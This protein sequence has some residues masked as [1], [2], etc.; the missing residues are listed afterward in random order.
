MYFLENSRARALVKYSRPVI[1]A[2]AK[3][4]VDDDDIYYVSLLFS[5]PVYV[6]VSEIYLAV[7]HFKC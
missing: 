3:P 1:P 2:L 7:T 6:L 5:D 4:N